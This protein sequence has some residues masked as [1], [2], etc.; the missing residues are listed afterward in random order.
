MRLP[1]AV[2]LS[3]RK[4]LWAIAEE[5][6]WERLSV[7]EKTLCY[8]GWARDPDIGGVLERYMDLRRVHVYL[9]DTI[10][11]EYGRSRLADASTAFRVLG[12]S[13]DVAVIETYQ[14]PHGRTL[15]DGRV[16]CW[17]RAEDW[18][19]ILMAVHERAFVDSRDPHAA[20]LMSSIGK[21]HNEEDRAV[22]VNAANKLDITKLIWLDG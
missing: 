19:G 14:K 2:R 11:K 18:K 3:I 16:I 21:F 15:A 7:S 5:I 22:V 20:V 12:V 6:S 8:E 13:A 10:M 1:D 4:R 17:G 9:K